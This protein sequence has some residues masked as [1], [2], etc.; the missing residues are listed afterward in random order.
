MS[1]DSPEPVAGC[2]CLL[3]CFSLLCVMSRRKFGLK[4]LTSLLEPIGR[5]YPSKMNYELSTPGNR[6]I[7]AEFNIDK[8]KL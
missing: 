6:N 2:G 5:V 1:V 8:S 4:C 3:L 7:L